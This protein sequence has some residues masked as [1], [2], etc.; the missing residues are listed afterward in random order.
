[1]FWDTKCEIVKYKISTCGFDKESVRSSEVT[2]D[3]CCC[4]PDLFV[5]FKNSL[6]RVSK[7]DLQQN[8]TSD[9]QS[10]Q[11]VVYCSI[12]YFSF[13]MITKE[14]KFYIFIYHDLINLQNGANNKSEISHLR[15]P[16]FLLGPPGVSLSVS[17]S[18]IPSALSPKPPVP[19]DT[20]SGLLQKLSQSVIS[21]HSLQPSF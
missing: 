19:G 7:S 11:H 12:L 8:K 9:M 17:G 2:L 6:I 1:M 13:Q 4:T 20:T 3:V 5:N 21:F 15:R 10:S 14:N 16:L 18:E